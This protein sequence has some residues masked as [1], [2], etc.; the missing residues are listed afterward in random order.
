MAD[1]MRIKQSTMADIADET[2]EIMGITG[3]LSPAQMQEQL[4]AAN[5]EIEEQ[6]ALIAEI[7]DI[8]ATKAGGSGGG[9]VLETGTLTGATTYG[10]GM[11]YYYYYD[12]S[13]FAGKLIVVLSKDAEEIIVCKRTSADENFSE[14][15]AVTVGVLTPS[16][17]ETNVVRSANASYDYFAV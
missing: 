12:L 8:L 5:A 14:C 1:V 3:K 17:I 15:N 11:S 4:A 9:A 13:V 7:S 6:A 10:A 16:I 2:R